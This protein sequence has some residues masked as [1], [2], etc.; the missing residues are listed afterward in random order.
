M[1][2]EE[3]GV[4]SNKHIVTDSIN[5]PFTFKI[6]NWFKMPFFNKIDKP[7]SLSEFK[8]LWDNLNQSIEGIVFTGFK[9]KVIK[10]Q[11][12]DPKALAG[13]TIDGRKYKTL[14]QEIDYLINQS[15]KD[16]QDMG[17]LKIYFNE[18]GDSAN[19]FSF[20]SYGGIRGAFPGFYEIKGFLIYP[21]YNSY[22]IHG[23][24]ALIGIHNSN[25]LL[26]EFDDVFF[27]LNKITNKYQD[28]SLDKIVNVLKSEEGRSR[29]LL[30]LFGVK[31]PSGEIIK[32]IVPIILTLQLYFFIHLN[33]FINT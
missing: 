27:E 19:D 17:E 13:I 6:D 29:D 11:E 5:I 32:W 10:L 33:Q 28:L 4:Y 8:I 20:I 7:Q 21:A 16:S 2:Q 26:G 9:S 12:E 31:I 22:L 30:E 15:H 3:E 1:V 25:I 24:Q 14:N 23:Q 18:L